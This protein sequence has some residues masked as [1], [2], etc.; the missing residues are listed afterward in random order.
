MLEGREQGSKGE[1]SYVSQQ[2]RNWSTALC[3]H[4]LLFGTKDFDKILRLDSLSY[5]GLHLRVY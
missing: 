3:K 4:S 5:S 1:K 2:P